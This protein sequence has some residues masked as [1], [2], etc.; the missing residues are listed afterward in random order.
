[1]NRLSV[2]GVAA[3]ALLAGAWVAGTGASADD[4]PPPPPPAA[5]LATATQQ[6]AV[7]TPIAPCRIV[8]TRIGGGTPFGSQV[9]RTYYASGTTG[10]AP[11]GGK[12][13]GCGIPVGTTAIAAV[14]TAVDPAGTGWLRAWPTGQS[15][16]GASLVQ[17]SGTSNGSGVTL[18]VNPAA[19]K[20]LAIKNY[21]GTTDVTVD[22]TGYYA[23][24]IYGTFTT[25]GNLFNGNGTLSPY[26][27]GSTG[28]YVVQANRSLNGCTPIV[29]SY[30]YAYNVSAYVDDKYIYIQM[31]NYNGNQVDYYFQVQVTC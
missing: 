29:S 25:A 9:S 31:T 4:A 27:H 13:G 28:Y 10:F 6:G 16:P 5:T 8:D 1:M 23:P 7:L 18:A 17:Y 21:A 14:I 2:I 26:S 3:L 11:Q 12:S 19:G 30:Y 24:Q 22:V 15:E 20:N